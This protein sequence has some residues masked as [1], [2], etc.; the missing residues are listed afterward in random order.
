MATIIEQRVIPRDG[1][2]GVALRYDNG[3]RVA[4]PVGSREDAERELL[5]P[6][7]PWPTLDAPVLVGHSRK[8]RSRPWGAGGPIRTACLLVRGGVSRVSLLAPTF[9]TQINPCVR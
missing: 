9:L 6:D 3:T 8:W 7:P 2:W 4:Y 5:D 1:K